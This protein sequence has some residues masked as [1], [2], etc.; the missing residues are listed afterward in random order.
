MRWITQKGKDPQRE[1]REVMEGGGHGSEE[2]REEE[3]LSN[4]VKSLTIDVV[5]L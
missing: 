1:E 4:L 2:G 3:D 5:H